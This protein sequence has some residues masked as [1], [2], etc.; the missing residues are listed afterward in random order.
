MCIRDSM[1]ILG[2]TLSEQFNFDTHVNN[3]AIKARQSMYALRVLTAHGLKGQ[4]LCDVTNVTTVSRM[5]YAAP[6]WWGFVG[7]EGRTLGHSKTYVL[8][9]NEL[10]H[11]Q[12]GCSCP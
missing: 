5:L 9:K 7:V 3:I 11:N 6:A 2:V 4:S 8:V 12:K 1:K 10:W